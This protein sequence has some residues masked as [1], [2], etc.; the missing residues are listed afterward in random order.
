MA[1]HPALLSEAPLRHAGPVT[2]TESDVVA[3]R[4]PFLA[5]TVAV[6]L[7]VVAIIALAAITGGIGPLLCLVVCAG[8]E[9]QISRAPHRLRKALLQELAAPVHRQPGPLQ[10]SISGGTR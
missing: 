5:A 6:G 10:W 9:R 2:S 3:P 1:G 7:V 8:M 4:A